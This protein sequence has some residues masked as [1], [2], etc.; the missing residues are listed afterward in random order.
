[1][2][3]TVIIR[4]ELSGELDS[5]FGQGGILTTN[6]TGYGEYGYDLTFQQ[7]GKF[8]V[9][10]FTSTPIGNDL[11][12][13]RYLPNGILDTSFNHTGWAQYGEDHQS[14]GGYRILIQPDQKI[15]V[16]GILA[17]HHSPGQYLV[18][19]RL[20]PNGQLDSSFGEDGYVKLY[21]GTGVIPIGLFWSEGKIIFG[22]SDSS[23]VLL[24]EDGSF[25]ETFGNN[26]VVENWMNIYYSREMVLQEDKKILF[27]GQT[28][29]Y[30]D[31][32]TCLAR[33]MPDGSPDTSF[34][35][36]GALIL[37]I[38]DSTNV[39]WRVATAP[40]NRI[41]VAGTANNGNNG[42]TDLA[43]A[44]IISDLSIGTLDAPE[45]LHE[46][47]LYP[48][49]IQ[50]KE[51]LE[52][53][54]TTEKHVEVSLWDLNGRLLETLTPSTI[55]GIGNHKESITLSNTLPSGQYYVVIS[56]ENFKKSIKIIKH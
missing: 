4:L 27:C 47:L 24:N 9:T 42:I 10:G 1:M 50:S 41:V 16:A 34:A 39:W 56:S 31:Y 36:N 5:S 2:V 35:D 11:L 19:T 29:D 30:P 15:L 44:Q 7:D 3:S 37:N 51:V 12:V 6:V 38:S 20:L 25:D 55:R 21:S 48:N 8:V 40:N 13:Y 23:L 54:L 33:F 45:H 22:N 49:P 14:E 52:Y 43:L 28:G 46:V 17:F 26:G 53:A 32:Q 18:L